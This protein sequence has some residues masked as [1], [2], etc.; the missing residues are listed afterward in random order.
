MATLRVPLLAL[1]VAAASGCAADHAPPSGMVSAATPEA[2]QAGLEILAAGGNAVDAAAAVS[3]ALGVTEPAASG[4]GGQTVML[5][6][7]PGADAVVLDGSSVAPAAIPADA[8]PHDLVGHR[9]TTVPTTVKT[10]A[11]ALEELGSGMVG[12]SDVLAPA[13]RYA[14][15]GY[16]LDGSRHR[17]LVRYQ[18][19]IRASPSVSALF[20][21]ADGSVPERGSLHRQPALARTLRRLAEAGPEDFYGG[22]I[23]AAIDRDMRANGGWLTAADLADAPEPKLVTPITGTY[24]GHTVHT[25]PP[26]YGGWIVLAALAA[27]DAVPADALAVRGA[28]RTLA[29]AEALR[30]A[31]GMRLAEPVPDLDAWDAAVAER[32][33]AVRAARHMGDRASVPPAGPSGDGETT[34]FSIVD[35]D[36]MAVAVTQSINSYYGAKVA[37]PELG[38]PYNSYM[39]EFETG[40]PDHTFALRPGARPLSSMSPTVVG[41]G[42]LVLGGPGS[43][44]IISSVVQVV[45]NVLDRGMPVSD[46]VA[47]PRVHVIP[48]ASGRD[49]LYLEGLDPVFDAETDETGITRALDVPAG[50][51]PARLGPDTVVALWGGPV[52]LERAVGAG[53]AVNGRRP[54]AVSREDGTPRLS[55]YF[56]GVHA[57]RVAAD[58]VSGAADP[59]RD[60]V[61][62]TDDVVLVP[63]ASGTGQ[64]RGL[65][66][67]SPRVAWATGTDG[68]YV[69]TVDGGATWRTGTI[70]GADALFLVDVHAV[71]ADTAI[72]PGTRFDGGLARIYRTDDGGRSWRVV[73]E[74]ARAGAFYDG[75][76]CWDAR[77]CV[78]FGDP[79]DGRLTVVRT[80]DGETW[81][82][83]SSVPDAL[84]GEAGFAASGTAIA[85]AGTRRAWI[86]TGGGERARVYRTDDGGVTWT[87]VETPL[88]AGPTAGIF[89]IAF[90]DTLQG[91]AV[92]GDYARP[93]DPAPNVLRTMDGGRSWALVGAT[94]PPGVKWGLAVGRTRDG[95][96]L[97]LAVSPAGSGYSLDGVTWSA[98]ADGRYN[99]ATFAGGA[100]WAAGAG[101][102]VAG[103]H[104]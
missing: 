29:L 23:A 81:V 53:F 97:W 32:I 40:D 98:V 33:D 88:P 38:F 27:L 103:I 77:H 30:Y 48:A 82:P 60:G 18:G 47:E 24:R 94:T 6:Y 28:R 1:L 62:A 65:S 96:T 2:A 70:P 90:V 56:G 12:W 7:R 42:A 101:G 21:A 11:F 5:V 61:T 75:L 10:L 20:L 3:L 100:G 39:L 66:A 92:G 51:G 52:L 19:V 43:A 13:I 93:E 37:A 67:S 54:P 74:D 78:A 55:S 35:R 49:I 31:H 15:D 69:R 73:H 36:G 99:T 79:V 14:E 50:A 84:P 91:L 22:E 59:R 95:G 104:F 63:Q 9:L 72:V 57:V 85:T 45:S 68:G 8:T 46:A 89:G 71:S 44:R 80:G 17:S 34:H 4:L 83:A 41:N 87:A 25:A 58:G 102:R 16:P 64:Y 76:A 86:G 26:P